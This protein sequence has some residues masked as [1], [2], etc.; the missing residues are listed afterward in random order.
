MVKWQKKKSQSLMNRIWM[1]KEVINRLIEI[2]WRK[3][4]YN[5]TVS[6]FLN[7]NQKNQ[8]MNRA[9]LYSKGYV[10]G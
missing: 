8:F 5:Q 6:K 1:Q 3:L 4:T 10:R 7:A 2:L 9:S